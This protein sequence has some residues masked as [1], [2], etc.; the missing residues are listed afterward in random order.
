VITVHQLGQQAPTTSAASWLLPVTLSLVLLCA[1][2][3]VYNTPRGHVTRDYRESLGSLGDL[4]FRVV[5][6]SGL[7]PSRPQHSLQGRAAQLTAAAVGRA[8]VTL[9]LIDAT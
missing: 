8:D 7:E 6:T 5:D 9:L 1:A 3:Q 2:H 4:Q